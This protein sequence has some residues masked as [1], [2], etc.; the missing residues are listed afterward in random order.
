[1]LCKASE[2]LFFSVNYDVIHA[3]MT[4]YI[5]Q[6][7]SWILNLGFFNCSEMPENPQIGFEKFENNIGMHYLQSF[8]KKLF[9]KS[10]NLMK[11]EI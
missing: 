7:R 5:K 9:V 11:T 8:W 4:S 2:N 3:I 6:I 1:M 10:E